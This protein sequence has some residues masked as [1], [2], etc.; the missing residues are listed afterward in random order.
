MCE[1]VTMAIAGAALSGAQHIMQSRA[2]DKAERQRT[3]ILDEGLNG[4]Q[5]TQQAINDAVVNSLYEHE[6][7]RVQTLYEQ[8]AAR[9]GDTL[10]TSLAEAQAARPDKAA[11]GKLSEAY[12]TQVARNFADE[13]EDAIARTQ[14]A[15]RL[16]APTNVNAALGRAQN[17]VGEEVQ[18]QVGIGQGQQGV[19]QLQLSSVREEP[20]LL[21]E[22]AGAAGGSM[23]TSGLGGI[24]A[25]AAQTPYQAALARQGPA[26]LAKGV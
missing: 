17:R 18:R 21:G 8:E 19:T 24:Y 6:P 12:T 2:T 25:G 4:Q 20:S 13:Q 1:P 16:Q 7:A 14:R 23:L 11:T 15:A 10:Q 22:L 5:R 26:L 9:V 3:A